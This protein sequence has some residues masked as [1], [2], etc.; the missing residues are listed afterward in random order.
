MRRLEF[1]FRT[2]LKAANF[3]QRNGKT[4]ST[5]GVD[6]HEKISMIWMRSSVGVSSLSERFLDVTS[7]RRME[8]AMIVAGFCG[9]ERMVRLGG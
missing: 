5:P 1:G 8:S 9:R 6:G 2:R 3:M 4:R 7:K